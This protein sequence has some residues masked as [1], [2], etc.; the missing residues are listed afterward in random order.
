[1]RIAVVS[2]P[3]F[4]LGSTGL[5]GYG[6]LE[7]I[8]WHCAKGLAEMGNQVILVAPD[9]SECPGVQV[10]PI[11][12]ERQV[13]EKQA[14]DKYWQLLLQV[15]CVIDHSWNKWAYMIKA[16]GRLK[17]PV[18]GVMHAPINTMIAQPPPV[19]KPC[20]V[21]ISEDQRQHYEALFAP[22]KARTCYNGIDLSFYRPLGVPRTDRFLFLARFSEIKGAD[23]AIEACRKV[24][25]GLDLIGDTTITNEPE[26]FHRCKA[27]CDGE[28]IRMVGACSRSEAVWWYSQ[29]HALIHA[30]KRFREPFG[31]AP[32]E[33][34]A[35]GTPV[36]AW[37]YG[38]MRETVVELLVDSEEK[39]ANAVRHIKEGG[40]SQASR[41]TCRKHAEQFSAERMAARYFDLC[42]EAVESGGW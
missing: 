41:D 38:A 27:M 18:L 7:Q 6:G 3:V 26:Y 25:A 17:A 21:C 4:R 33:S 40:I 9:N 28:Q 20:I 39:L 24:G 29:A 11:G 31:L 2:T 32:V 36:I 12:P 34:L 35:C 1:M 42:R 23:L 30:N 5:T 16:E 10:F 15:E 14:Y 37:D 19:A 13:D 22:R 8:A